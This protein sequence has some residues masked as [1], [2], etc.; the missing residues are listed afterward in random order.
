MTPTA[1][2]CASPLAGASWRR[3]VG[4]V[5]AAASAAAR[6]RLRADHAE[7]AVRR[8][9]HVRAAALRP[10]DCRS[11]SQ[12][13][14]WSHDY[15]TGE[16]HFMKILN[17][18]SYLDPH[19]EETQHPRRS[20]IPELF[21][22]PVAYMAEPGFWTLTDEEAAAFRAYLLKGGFVIFDD[23]REHARRLGQ[24][25]GADAPRA[26]GR[27]V[28]RPR[29]VASDLPL[30]LRDRRRSTSS[31]SPTI[32]AGRSSAASSRTTTRRSG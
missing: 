32:A 12:R 16:R 28:R 31:R 23:F 29:R 4:A 14:P 10:A 19:I 5:R 13:M 26:A 17:E 15:P 22:Y 11:S 9:V 8:A 6:R 21:K 27:P 25:R 1:S 30:V 24:L 20:T 2:S 7:H 3:G 18:V